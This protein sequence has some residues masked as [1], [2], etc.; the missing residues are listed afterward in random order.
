MARNIWAISDT[1]FRHANILTFTHS[2]DG[3]LIRPGFATVDEMDEFML[4]KWNSVV[5]PGDI[6][7]HLGDV[8]MGPK[9][10]FIPFFNKLNG[11]KRLCVGN[12]DDIKWLAPSGMFSK[13]YMWR[14][15][16]DFGFVLSHVPLH[17]SSLLRP[18]DTDEPVLNVHGHIHQ[19]DSP[20]GPYVNLSVEK[21]DYTPVHIEEIRNLWK[22]QQKSKSSKID[23]EQSLASESA[24]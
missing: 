15:F 20:D 10:G 4:E 2:K 22:Q 13:V 6:V 16:R 14:I 12:H 5:M 9:E 23:T 17:P 24:S 11:R 21:I 18:V 3:S 19:N 8:V 1:H 7:Y